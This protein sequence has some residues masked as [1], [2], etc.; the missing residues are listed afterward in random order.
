MDRSVLDV[1]LTGCWLRMQSSAGRVKT[2]L[3]YG[4]IRGKKQRFEVIRG[5]A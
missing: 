3:I 4:V 1:T 5:C 2:M